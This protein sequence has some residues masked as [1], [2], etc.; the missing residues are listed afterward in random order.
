MSILQ[1]FS[2]NRTSLAQLRIAHHASDTPTARLIAEI[3]GLEETLLGNHRQ[4]ARLL[5]CAAVL[6]IEPPVATPAEIVAG[7]EAAF[8]AEP[9]GCS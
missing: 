1:L 2:R 6:G 8:E 7:A 3:R 9:L 5:R 4:Y